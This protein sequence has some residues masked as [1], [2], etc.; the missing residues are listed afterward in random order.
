MRFRCGLISAIRSQSAWPLKK[1]CAVRPWTVRA[2]RA[3]GFDGGGDF[4]GGDVVA[5]A[6]EAD[7]GGDGRRAAGC[8]DALD[9]AADALAD[10][11]A[12]TSRCGRVAA[13]S[14]TGQPKLMIDHAD[15]V[16][17]G[18][19]LADGGER[20]RIVIPHLHGQRARFVGDAPEA[21]GGFGLFFLIHPGEGPG[22]NHF[23]GLQADAA[24]L[25]DHLAIGVVR[26]AR[27]RGLEQGRIDD[28]RA[29]GQRFYARGGEY[30][31]G[32][33]IVGG[34]HG[35]NVHDCTVFAT[36]QPIEETSNITADFAD[37]ADGKGKIAIYRI[38]LISNW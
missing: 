1:S 19:A 15:V 2:A 9:D 36:I 38:R 29:N 24:E 34:D 35:W 21:V 37:S 23:G 4:D 22:G 33:V 28:E 3:G 30:R 14:L 26:E 8:D 27:H 16:F 18:Q 12:S 5:R 13:T 32:G 10:R 20:F 7:F 11:G 17:A 31:G 25:A 6:A